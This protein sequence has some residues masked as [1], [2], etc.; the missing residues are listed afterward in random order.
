MHH[1]LHM[2]HTVCMP[3]V[4]QICTAVLLV[5]PE[6]VVTLKSTFRSYMLST[7][8]FLNV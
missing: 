7:A 2:I 1:G 6:S 3:G 5:I 8:V 4:S